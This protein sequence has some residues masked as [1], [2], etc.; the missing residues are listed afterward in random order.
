MMAVLYAET[1]RHFNVFINHKC[2]LFDCIYLLNTLETQRHGQYKYTVYLCILCDFQ[3]ENVTII[4]VYFLE[5]FVFVMKTPNVFC[6]V[7]T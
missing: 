7:V 5:W 1:C 3:N 4:L 6:E 2:V